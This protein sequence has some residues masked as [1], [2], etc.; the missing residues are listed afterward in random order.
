M[1][2]RSN[3]SGVSQWTMA[4]I[5]V[6]CL[7]VL[8]WF[9]VQAV[10]TIAGARYTGTNYSLASN[11]VGDAMQA[12]QDAKTTDP[13]A[14]RSFVTSYVSTSAV[15]AA[16]YNAGTNTL[17]QNLNTTSSVLQAQIDT[18]VPTNRT[19]TVTFGG[20]TFA[21]GLNSNGTFA[22][23]QATSSVSGWLGS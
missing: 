3:K 19:F 14:K 13:W 7:L 22:L 8:G 15:T 17:Q 2:F 5:G 21:W 9:Q 12:A 4:G 16:T 20:T 18:K 11:Q 10:T 23:P 6:I 1:I